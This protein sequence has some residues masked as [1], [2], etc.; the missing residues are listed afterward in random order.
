MSIK[1]LIKLSHSW[2]DGALWFFFCLQSYIFWGISI[3]KYTRP[4]PINLLVSQE[5][6]TSSLQLQSRIHNE[7][8]QCYP[9]IGITQHS[10][11][12]TMYMHCEYFCSKIQAW[13]TTI[14]NS[15]H[16]ILY[17][18]AHHAHNYSPYIHVC[19]RVS[20]NNFEI[21]R[22]SVV[23][24]IW[25]QTRVY[26]SYEISKGIIEDKILRIFDEVKKKS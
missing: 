22:Y 16:S 23:R 21:D 8:A 14:K 5:D 17:I 25:T 15:I 1:I 4:L 6:F 7:G 11:S 9:I 26:A 20:H 19:L 12:C 24:E 13:T 18:T 10:I 2:W 3:V